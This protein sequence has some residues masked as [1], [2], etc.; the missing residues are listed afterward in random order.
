M[1]APHSILT[2]PLSS[3]TITASSSCPCSWRLYFQESVTS[4]P[5]NLWRLP[6]LSPGFASMHGTMAPW[7]GTLDEAGHRLRLQMLRALDANPLPLEKASSSTDPAPSAGAGPLV[8]DRPRAHHKSRLDTDAEVDRAFVNPPAHTQESST[9]RTRRFRPSRAAA[10]RAARS[11]KRE[12]RSSKR[13]GSPP[14]SSP[15][16]TSS[17]PVITCSQRSFGAFRQ[18]VLPPPCAPL[19]V[20]SLHPC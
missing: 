3:I 11:A 7:T 14:P 17:L 4:S 2:L 1:I 5:F 9:R 18:Y 12:P 6:A 8:I 10:Q 20:G 16:Y 19:R 15:S 13:E